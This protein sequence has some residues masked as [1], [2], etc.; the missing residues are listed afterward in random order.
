MTVTILKGY[1]KGKSYL[2]D[3]VGRGFV[4]YIYRVLLCQ[5]ICLVNSL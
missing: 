2:Q 3:P 5:Y 4:S 1:G